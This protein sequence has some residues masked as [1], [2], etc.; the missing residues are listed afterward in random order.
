MVFVSTYEFSI[1]M[2]NSRKPLKDRD[3]NMRNLKDKNLNDREKMMWNNYFHQYVLFA[4]NKCFIFV[5]C[6]LGP[7]F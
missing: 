6:Y 3:L 7:P 4:I 2:W 1:K 5:F